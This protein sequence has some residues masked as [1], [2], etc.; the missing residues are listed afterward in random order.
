MSDTRR[1]GQI[2]STTVDLLDKERFPAALPTRK[3][4]VI[5]LKDFLSYVSMRENRE[6]W[7]SSH[8]IVFGRS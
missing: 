1:Q 4:G 8:P 5:R 6:L 3:I 7:G 2:D